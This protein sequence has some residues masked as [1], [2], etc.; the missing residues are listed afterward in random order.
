MM[1]I[2]H[3]KYLS[4]SNHYGQLTNPKIQKT[5]QLSMR[6]ITVE[7]LFLK[8]M[9]VFE[10][11]G[12]RSIIRP[13]CFYNACLGHSFFPPSFLIIPSFTQK[14]LHLESSSI[15]SLS[16]PPVGTNYAELVPHF[17]VK[18]MSRIIII[19]PVLQLFIERIWGIAQLL[20]HSLKNP[21]RGFLQPYSFYV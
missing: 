20:Q 9:R 10:F 13:N 19:G 6:R 8:W 14:T 18:I 11:C 2:I 4:K 7:A 5:S 1:K 3:R 16:L 21:K 12:V 15:Y 17:L